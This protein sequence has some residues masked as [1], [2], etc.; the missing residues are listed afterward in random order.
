MDRNEIT[1]CIDA[2][3]AAHKFQKNL[4]ADNL[5]KHVQAE[6]ESKVYFI[7]ILFCII[8]FRN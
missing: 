5:Q 3:T 8:F 2:V 6:N 1:N 7:L 4:L